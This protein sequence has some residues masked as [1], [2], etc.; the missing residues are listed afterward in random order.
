MIELL[1]LVLLSFAVT[2]IFLVPFIDFLYYLKKKYKRPIPKG[3]D[4]SHTPIHNQLLI[5]KDDETPVGGGILLLLVI[6][7]LS[8]GYVIIQRSAFPNDLLILIFSLVSFGV[9]GLFD[10]V[11]K[12]VTAFSGKYQGIRGRYILLLQ[13][14]FATLLATSLYFVVGFNSF[15]ISHIGN[16]VLGLWYIPIAAFVIVAFSNA[17][18]I[19]DGLDGLST[20]LLIICL[21]ALLGLA[22]ANLNLTLARFL[23]IWI[24]TLFAFLYFNIYPARIYLGD[25]A[26][27]AF[28]A[29]FAVVGL[30]TGKMLG[31]AVIGGVYVLIVATSFLQIFWKKVFKK[32][33]FPVAPL[34]MLLVYIGWK[35]PKVVMRLWLVQALFSIFGLWLA[36][37][38][39]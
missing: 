7:V 30:L 28:G 25:A 8:L 19:S 9:I 23:G 20:G 32:K 1:G 3:Y 16:F 26:A 13:V 35:E 22:S 15:Y 10:D 36:L 38:S 17:Y 27:L 12:I 39:Q 37:L 4:N 24:G 5:G 34:H 14:I 33:L 31:L 2:A 21:L 6:I 18:N 11:K 29:T